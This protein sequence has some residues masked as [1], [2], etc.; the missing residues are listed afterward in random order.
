[1]EDDLEG[2]S[3]MVE[4]VPLT[5]DVP[6]SALSSGGVLSHLS[7]PEAWMRPSRP[8]YKSP[9]NPLAL[10]AGLFDA[11]SARYTCVLSNVD[12][13][14]AA[15]HLLQLL[16]YV[17]GTLPMP[18]E[19][20]DGTESDDADWTLDLFTRENGSANVSRSVQCPTMCETMWFAKFDDISRPGCAG[21]ALAPKSV[22]YSADQTREWLVN[23]CHMLAGSRE[24]FVR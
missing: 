6:L 13:T 12:P 23:V 17:M 19:V 10:S 7:P 16:P 3:E 11:R 22:R 9:Y 8:L 14:S 18:K 24:P 2:A 21:W 4:P 15:A 5:R 20:Q 1:M